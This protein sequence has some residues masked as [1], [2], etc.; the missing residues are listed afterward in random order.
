MGYP[1]KRESLILRLLFVFFFQFCFD[2]PWKRESLILRL[3]FVCSSSF[4]DGVP[5]E[6][7]ILRFEIAFCLFFQY[8]LM[9]YP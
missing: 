3:L 7:G 1:W 8:F 5:L 2:D 6:K 4:F 9:R